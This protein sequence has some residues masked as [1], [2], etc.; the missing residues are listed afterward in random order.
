[1][2]KSKWKITYSKQYVVISGKNYKLNKKN[3]IKAS[4]LGVPHIFGMRIIEEV[5]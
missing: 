2:K 1:M 4:K 3:L 5:K